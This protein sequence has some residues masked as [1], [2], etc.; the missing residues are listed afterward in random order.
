MVLSYLPE[1]QNNCGSGGMPFTVTR[2]QTAPLHEY[3]QPSVSDS[4]WTMPGTYGRAC[5]SPHAYFIEIHAILVDPTILKAMGVL[6]KTIS[7]LRVLQRVALHTSAVLQQALASCPCRCLFQAWHIHELWIMSGPTSL[8][9][10]GSVS[11]LQKLDK[12]RYYRT[13]CTFFNVH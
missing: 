12:D 11:S 10:P 9:E 7:Y 8:Q 4:R 5:L 3:R 6:T 2:A 1:S 13:V